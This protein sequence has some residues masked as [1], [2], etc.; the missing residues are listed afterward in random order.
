MQVVT[1]H[2]QLKMHIVRIS[3][4]QENTGVLCESGYTDDV[5]QT[6]RYTAARRLRPTDS[7]EI[8]TV[9]QVVQNIFSSINNWAETVEWFDGIMKIKD[10]KERERRR[11]LDKRHGIES[12]ATKSGE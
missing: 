11:R 6:M 4:V 8:I 9:R 2:G 5:A 12:Y 1:M 10:G 3:K 7:K